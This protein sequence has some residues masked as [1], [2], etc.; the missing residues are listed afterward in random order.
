M[1][2]DISEIADKLSE[3]AADQLDDVDSGYQSRDGVTAED[4][5]EGDIDD[6]SE[7]SGGGGGEEDPDAP[8]EWG[9]EAPLTPD[10][11]GVVNVGARAVNW[12][13]NG[14]FNP[15][16]IKRIDWN[17]EEDTMEQRDGRIERRR[18][19]QEQA[20]EAEAAEH[21]IREFFRR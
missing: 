4:D 14:R 2:E 10:L 12:A 20:E 19:R 8:P 18:E 5:G 1:F 17:G 15:D 13:V 16:G 6:D 9:A 11:K 3:T 21:P 7:G